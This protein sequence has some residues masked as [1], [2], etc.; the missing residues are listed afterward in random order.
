MSGEVS[1]GVDRALADL[2]GGWDGG[3]TLFAV[4][5]G[6]LARQAAEWAEE[7]EMR[8]RSHPAG[9]V[10]R[11]RVACEDALR[12]AELAAEIHEALDPEAPSEER[13]A[14]LAALLLDR[15]RRLAL[16]RVA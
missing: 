10:H 14:D 2:V 9:A 12:T 13:A 7:G 4:A 3:Y 16:E 11:L 8:F 15:A 6:K 5:A 1:T